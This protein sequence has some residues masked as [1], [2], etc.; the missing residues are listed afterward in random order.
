MM[1]KGLL[2]LTSKV[3]DKIGEA[4]K[5]VTLRI[6]TNTQGTAQDY[7]NFLILDRRKFKGPPFLNPLGSGTSTGTGTSKDKGTGTGKATPLMPRMYSNK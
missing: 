6:D 7:N 3:D 2:K 5:A 1:S 4:T